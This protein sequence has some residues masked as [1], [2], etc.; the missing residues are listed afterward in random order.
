M[1]GI[2]LICRRKSADVDTMLSFLVP[3]KRVGSIIGKSGETINKIRTETN[4]QISISKH[5]KGVEER[6]VDV[7]GSLPHVYAAC[8]MVIEQLRQSAE[9]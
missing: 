6:R 2:C 3:N 9:E 8:E 4:T 5:A 7:T 1:K